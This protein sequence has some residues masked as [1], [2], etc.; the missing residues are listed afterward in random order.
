MKKVLL[1][2]IL[3]ANYCYAQKKDLA[4]AKV[5]YM[6]KHIND[7]TQ[8]QNFLRDETVTYIGQQGSYYTSFSSTRLSEQMNAKLNDPAF[9]GALTLT[10]NTTAIK[11]NYLFKPFDE[12]FSEIRRLVNDYYV[13]KADIPELDW[14]IEEETREIGGYLCQKATARFKGRDYTA[15]FT[16]ELPFS[17]GPWKLHGLPGL[18]LEAYDSKKEVVFEYNGFDKEIE[19]K[20]TPIELPEKALFVSMA[21]FKKQENAFEANPEA[22]RNA[23]LG[24]SGIVREVPTASGGTAT[25]RA[26]G[27]GTT[28][29]VGG[30][31]SGRA[32]G[33]AIDV[34]KIKSINVKGDDNYK[35]S[36]NTNNPIELEPKS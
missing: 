32:G 24:T 26:V 5:H 14:N 8:P 35:P 29:V 21:E 11:E 18:I 23:R 31:S 16:T 3:I 34:S 7:T 27:T 19:G 15:W 17:Y 2:T 25:I 9:D 1:L 20:P 6:F 36:Q 30:S 12:E 33:S 4:V 22:Y 28:T 13:I 10:R